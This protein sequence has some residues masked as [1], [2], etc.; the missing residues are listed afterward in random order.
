MFDSF[1]ILINIELT[2]EHCQ[3]PSTQTLAILVVILVFRPLSFPAWCWELGD[4]PLG[5]LS[6]LTCR[7]AMIPQEGGG[8]LKRLRRGSEFTALSLLP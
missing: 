4:G 7:G 2:M 1:C 5:C 3:L 6:S 8:I